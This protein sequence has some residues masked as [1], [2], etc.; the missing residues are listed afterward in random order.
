MSTCPQPRLS[1]GYGFEKAV[2]R[3]PEAVY[4][5]CAVEIARKTKIKVYVKDMST[6]STLGNCILRVSMNLFR[7]ISR[8]IFFIQEGD[9][10]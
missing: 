7:S 9:V 1:I 8:C 3:T 2:P 5:P 10:I 4:M 6:V